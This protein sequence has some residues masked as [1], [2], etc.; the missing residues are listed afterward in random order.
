MVPL[1]QEGNLSRL[2]PLQRAFLS[3]LVINVSGHPKRRREVNEVFMAL[4]LMSKR[5]QES[6][7]DRSACPSFWL[8]CKM[9]C[10]FLPFPHPGI[11]E[12]PPCLA[13]GGWF[14][15]DFICVGVFL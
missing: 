11:A 8:F 6:R 12:G 2:L 7:A 9:K 15:S 14:Y 10:G 3:S 4:W 5:K 1:E 13:V